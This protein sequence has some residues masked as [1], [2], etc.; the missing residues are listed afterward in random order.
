MKIKGKDQVD[1][2]NQEAEEDQA[3]QVDQTDQVGQVDQVDQENQD[4]E[5][6][7]KGQP[8]PP[9]PKEGVG[10]KSKVKEPDV[11]MGDHN[12]A[13]KFLANLYLLFHC[14]PNNYPNDESMVVT[15]LSYLCRDIRWWT[16]ATQRLDD[17]GQPRGFSTWQHFGEDFLLVFGEQDL[18]QTAA[19]Q[20]A[21][22]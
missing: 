12:Q 16:E 15:A 5:E 8:N 11:F 22:M 14:R 1:Q 21:T 19:V 17:N 7:T 4:V 10:H 20:L 9:R 3:G 6:G 13:N 18:V 2:E